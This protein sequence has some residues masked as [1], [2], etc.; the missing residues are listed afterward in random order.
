MGV[1]NPELVN[2][3]VSFCGAVIGAFWW[4]CFFS[5]LFSDKVE[6]LKIP[7][8]FDIGYIDE[9]CSP[10]TNVTALPAQKTVKRKEVVKPQP[11]KTSCDSKLFDECVGA[12]VNLGVKKAEA[13]RDAKRFFKNNSHVNDAETFILEIFKRN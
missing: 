2:I 8:R 3:L 12:L 11:V 4:L 10:V 7:E 13:T 1:D 5:G 6:P 9:E